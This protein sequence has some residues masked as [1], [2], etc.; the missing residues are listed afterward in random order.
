MSLLTLL[1]S[2]ELKAQGGTEGTFHFEDHIAEI[3]LENDHKKYSAI[4]LKIQAHKNGVPMRHLPEGTIKEK[5]KYQYKNDSLIFEEQ[6]SKW[7]NSIKWSKRSHYLV[8]CNRDFYRYDIKTQ[9]RL[10]ILIDKV[11]KDSLGYVIIDRQFPTGKDTIH[12]YIRHKYDAK[13]R[14]EET[15]SGPSSFHLGDKSTILSKYEYSGDTLEIL[16]AYIVG[17]GRDVFTF[18]YRKSTSADKLTITTTYFLP[19]PESSSTKERNRSDVHV[20]NIVKN[21]KGQITKMTHYDYSE[22]NPQWNRRS[23]VEVIYKK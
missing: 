17:K 1:L 11:V 2:Y 10:V 3:L 20:L 23:V 9:K 15:L 13:K 19:L 6:Y 14:L 12:Q 8:M 16:N 7:K 18:G 21:E 4:V 22:G 5:I